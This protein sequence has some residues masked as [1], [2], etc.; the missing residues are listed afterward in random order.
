MFNGWP[1]L[2]TIHR[3]ASVYVL[4]AKKCSF[5]TRTEIENTE[6]Y[7]GSHAYGEVKKF[8]NTPENLSI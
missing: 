1:L 2:A 8:K 4:A 7:W 3:V 6:T 5:E